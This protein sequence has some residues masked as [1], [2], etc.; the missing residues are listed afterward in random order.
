[1]SAHLPGPKEYEAHKGERT[2]QGARRRLQGRRALEARERLQGRGPLVSRGLRI[3]EHPL[4]HALWTANRLY[5][6]ILHRFSWDQPDPLPAQGGCILVCNHRSGVDPFILSA[7][8]GRIISFLIAEEYYRIPVC[9]SLFRWMQ[10]IPV[11]RDERDV[12]AT[13]KA[14]KALR[15]GRALCIFPEG[16]IM[17]GLEDARLGVGYLCLR[18]GAPVVPAL[19]MGTPDT[20][21]VGRSLCTPSRSTVR[22]GTPSYPPTLGQGRLD[23]TRISEMTAEIMSSIASLS[24]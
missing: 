9:R 6:K 20:P 12:A 3:D 14:L 23:R 16:G 7:C 22:F 17:R 4:S 1:M 2:S 13:R 5:C 21:S 18:S 24:G 10:C 11:K 19:L 8:T 15:E